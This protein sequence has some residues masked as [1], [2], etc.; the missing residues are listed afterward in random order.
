MGYLLTYSVPYEGDHNQE[1]DNLDALALWLDQNKSSYNFD[2]DN[3]DVIEIKQGV[4]VYQ[5]MR[6]F[7][8]KK[9]LA[10][11]GFPP[12][13][14]KAADEAHAAGLFE[15]DPPTDLP[16]QIMAQAKDKLGE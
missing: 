14:L 10:Q 9:E 6:N 15:T 13:V 5:L 4:D 12:E 8:Q 1:F 11:A 16:E 7:D 2:L 3:V